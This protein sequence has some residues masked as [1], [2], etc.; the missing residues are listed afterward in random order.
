MVNV[1]LNLNSKDLKEIITKFKTFKPWVRFGI[2]ICFIALIIALIVVVSLFGFRSIF[3]KN[4]ASQSIGDNSA[5]NVQ[6]QGDSNII[7]SP[8]PFELTYKFLEEKIIRER[9]YIITYEVNVKRP[10][11]NF[12]DGFNIIY[13]RDEMNC[14]FEW[15]GSN[16][17]T[18]NGRQVF[19][20]NTGGIKCY[21]MIPIIDN[22]KLFSIK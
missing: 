5:G 12:Q 7:N 10:S 11:G 6:I 2:I 1:N 18:Q 14:L 19:E 21:S 13:N 22:G 15:T 3:N 16:A 4:Y 8:P 20:N 9:Y 17:M